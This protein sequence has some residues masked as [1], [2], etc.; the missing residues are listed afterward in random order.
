M[1]KWLIKYKIANYKKKHRYVMD[2]EKENHKNQSIAIEVE[3]LKELNNQTI[4]KKMRELL[5]WE[6]TPGH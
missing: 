4:I 1:M 3:R 5:C 6:G 2:K